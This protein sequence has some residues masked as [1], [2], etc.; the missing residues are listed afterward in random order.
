MAYYSYVNYTGNGELT[1][2]SI[3]FPYLAKTHVKVFVQGILKTHNVHYTFLT[4][5]VIQ[6]S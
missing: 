5:S 3:P 1:N 2:F 6:F 4:A